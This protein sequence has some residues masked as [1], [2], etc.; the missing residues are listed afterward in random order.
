MTESTCL[1]LEGDVAGALE[2]ELVEDLADVVE[3]ILLQHLVGFHLIIL[4]SKAS[5]II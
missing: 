5:H 4:Q 3:L 1:Y 2:I